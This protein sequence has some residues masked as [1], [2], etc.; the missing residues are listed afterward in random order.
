MNEIT[1]EQKLLAILAHIAYFLG[2]LGFIIAPLIIFLFKKDDDFVYEHAKQALVAHL[3]ILTISFIV[4]FL[5]MLVIGVFL[6]P[7]VAIFWIILLVTSIIA[8][9]KALNGESYQYPLIQKLVDK[10]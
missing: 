6:L 1:G 9:S 7:I 2:G 5:C 10:L 3:T 8:A 4:S